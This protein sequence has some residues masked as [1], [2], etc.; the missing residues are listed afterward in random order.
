M[1][2]N[3]ILIFLVIP[4]ISL[5]LVVFWVYQFVQLMLLDDADFP[6]RYDKILWVVAF[7]LLFVVAPFAFLAWKWAWVTVRAGERRQP[8]QAQTPD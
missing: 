4:L 7:V 3:E 8:G 2:M 1:G 6:G 5:A